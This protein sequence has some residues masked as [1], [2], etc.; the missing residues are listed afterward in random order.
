MQKLEKKP[1]LSGV[2]HCLL[3]RMAPSLGGREQANDCLA[4]SL[5]LWITG[6]PRSLEERTHVKGHSMLARSLE[7]TAKQKLP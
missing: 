7:G 2:N 4:F 3:W 5:L 6:C 1:L